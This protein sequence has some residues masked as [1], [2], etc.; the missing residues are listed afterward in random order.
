MRASKGTTLLNVLSVVVIF[1]L[2]AATIFAL[3]VLLKKDAPKT[4]PTPMPTYSTEPSPVI[5]EPPSTPALTP[6]DMM[7]M[8]P[9]P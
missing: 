7:S 2:A 3:Y 1:M 8:P 9:A 6:F 5:T 4:E